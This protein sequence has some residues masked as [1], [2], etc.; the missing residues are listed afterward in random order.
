LTTAKGAD[1]NPAAPADAGELLGLRVQELLD[2]MASRSLV[3]AGGSAAALAVAMAAGLAAKAARYSSELWPG[4]AGAVA[5]ADGLRAKVAPLAHWD[6]EV[7]KEA[8]DALRRPEGRDQEER[9]A[10]I[11]AALELAARVPLSIAEL[12][13]DV[14]FLAAAVAE[15][16]EPDLRGE[17]ATAAVLAE[18]GARAAANLVEINLATRPQ[19]ERVVRARG[20]V[21]SASSARQRALT[22]GP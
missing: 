5:E 11:G 22:A 9:D 17:A 18:A 13:S 1:R 2:Q 14:A 4:A 12:A 6:A 20:L 21:E 16:A 3:P 7:Y 8:V 10:K 15:R 19:D